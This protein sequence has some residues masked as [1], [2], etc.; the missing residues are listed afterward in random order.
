MKQHPK[1]LSTAVVLFVLA[2]CNANAQVTAQDGRTYKTVQI[3]NQTWMAENLNVSTYRNGDSISQFQEN[4]KK[5]TFKKNVGWT[6]AFAGAWSYYETDSG[7]DSTYG[8]IYNGFAV[9]D[10]RGLAPE[11]WHIPTSEDWKQLA[12]ALGGKDEAGSKMKS[13]EGWEDNGNGTNESGFTGFPNGLRTAKGD[14]RGK[15]SYGY[16]WTSTRKIGDHAFVCY[17]FKGNNKFHFWTGE[18]LEFFAGT[19]VRCVKN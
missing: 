10:P 6:S 1:L 5:M 8:K 17:L 9:F 19:A 11:G 7:I 14:F 12:E 15:G 2:F 18:S 3:G 16:W 4:G 13:T